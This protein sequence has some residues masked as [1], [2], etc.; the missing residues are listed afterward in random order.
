MSHVSFITC[1][2]FSESSFCS[3]KGKKSPPK[4]KCLD[5]GKLRFNMTGTYDLLFNI[6]TLITFVKISRACSLEGEQ[7]RSLLNLI[8][9]I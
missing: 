9:T 2:A 5:E 3:G 6:I 8:M 7:F 4:F 1:M